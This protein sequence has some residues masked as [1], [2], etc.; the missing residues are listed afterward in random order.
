MQ[1][2][3]DVQGYPLISFLFFSFTYIHV[4]CNG[5]VSDGGVW[6][7]IGFAKGLKENTLHLPI[8]SPIAQDGV[9]VPDVLVADDAFP[10]SRNIMKPFAR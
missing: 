8:A 7:T 9:A 6:K 2:S 10:L 1:S 5:C 3:C 4:G